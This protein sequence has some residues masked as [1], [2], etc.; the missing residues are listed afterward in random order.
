MAR[1]VDSEIATMFAE[2]L[3]LFNLNF[4]KKNFQSG[5]WQFPPLPLCHTPYKTRM[6]ASSER[7]DG[8]D[9]HIPDF[10]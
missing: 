3:Y 4:F 2:Y 5:I 9:Y 1:T 6:I 10:F 8:S 7:E